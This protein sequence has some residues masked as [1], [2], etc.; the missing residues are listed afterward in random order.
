MVKNWQG[1]FSNR[2]L[3]RGFNYYLMDAVSGLVKTSQGYQA[4]VQGTEDYDV[5][6]DLKNGRLQSMSCD[7]PYAESGN[8]CKHMAAVL[9]AVEDRDEDLPEKSESSSGVEEIINQM[10]VKDLREALL[11]VTRN[12]NSIGT[13]ILTRYNHKIQS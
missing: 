6:I 9:Y 11:S 2:I 7:C 10:S 13:L 5:S 12:D 1:H 3:E 4:N 8:I